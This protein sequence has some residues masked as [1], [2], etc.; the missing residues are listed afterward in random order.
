ML[1]SIVFI[2]GFT[3]N[4]TTSFTKSELRGKVRGFNDLYNARVGSISR[5]EA[6]NFL[7]RHGIAEI[8]F[9]S[10]QEGLKAVSDGEVDAFVLNEL[11]LK[12]LV[13][14]EFSGRVKVIP[15]IFDEYFVSIALQDKSSLRKP[16][17]KAFLKFM[18]S[19]KWSELMNRY[20]R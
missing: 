3:A 10:T 13:K 4:I 20:I 5:S 17:N 18:K 1:F 19:E 6:S 12:Y 7:N 16:I 14:N 2:A 15:G 9:G 11:I 8:P